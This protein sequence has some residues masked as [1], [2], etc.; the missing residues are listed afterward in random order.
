MTSYTTGHQCHPTINSI[1]ISIAY[2]GPFIEGRLLRHISHE[3]YQHFVMHT[4]RTVYE[5][6]P[7]YLGKEFPNPQL[8]KVVEALPNTR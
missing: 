5:I 8:V 1:P 4:K 7:Q 3:L 6:L 2:F